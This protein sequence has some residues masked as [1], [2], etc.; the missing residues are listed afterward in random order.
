[1]RGR[2][3]PRRFDAVQRSTTP[4]GQTPSPTSDLCTL[5][6]AGCNDGWL[7][8]NEVKRRLGAWLEKRGWSDARLIRKQAQ[9]FLAS[10]ALR[11]A[12][13]MADPIRIDGQ[14]GVAGRGPELPCKCGA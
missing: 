6:R 7:S 10:L 3:N 14:R 4:S 12:E 9:P 13:K 5:F 11:G 2:L 1:M 8:E